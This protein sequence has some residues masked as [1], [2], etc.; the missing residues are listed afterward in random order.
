M[1]KIL[2]ELSKDIQSTEAMF[3]AMDTG[4]DSSMKAQLEVNRKLLESFIALD[5]KLTAIDVKFSKK[6]LSKVLLKEG[7]PVKV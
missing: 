2:E 7:A 4:L 5:K 1:N 6:V 3:K